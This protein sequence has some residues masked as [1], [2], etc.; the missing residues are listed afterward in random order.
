[1]EGGIAAIEALPVSSL[2]KSDRILR[3]KNAADL[4][5]VGRVTAFFLTGV[6]QAAFAFFAGTS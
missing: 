1:L 4:R 2:R 5:P 6:A 3:R